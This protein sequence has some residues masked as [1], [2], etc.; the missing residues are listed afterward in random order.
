MKKFLLSTAALLA[1]PFAPALAADIPV[2]QPPPAM[3]VPAYSGFSWSGVYIGAHG[4]AVFRDSDDSDIGCGDIDN[5]VGSITSGV[6]LPDGSPD[7]AA[8]DVTD[9][10]API[11]GTVEFFDLD[12]D[13]VALRG[14]A[15]DDDDDDE[16][17]NWHAGVQA[18]ANVQMGG[19]VLGAEGDF[20]WLGDSENESELTFD[21][22]L[23]D[24]TLATGYAGTGS[25]S[26]EDDM[27]WLATIRGRLGGAFGADGRFLGY[28]TG[29]L[30]IAG[31]DSSADASFEPLEA[32][33]PFTCLPDLTDTATPC[34]FGDDDDDD[35]TE[36]GF[37]VGLGGEYAFTNNVTFGAEYLF[38]GFDEGDTQTVTFN[39]A[40]GRSF[41]IS[42]DS[43]LEDMHLFRA[44]L[45]VLFSGLGG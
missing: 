16:D 12:G 27:E 37:A 42:H 24:P 17:W 6:D 43:G 18:G 25:V 15:D 7:C 21:Y 40:D 28:V 9:P 39:G 36:L 23:A 41:D 4:G 33:A 44:K 8:G 31:V 34:S 3:A 26:F 45:N 14:S 2:M 20:S 30:A 38:V 29:G 22:F 11:A 13:G 32:A 1:A 35:D 10:T 5:L 19:F